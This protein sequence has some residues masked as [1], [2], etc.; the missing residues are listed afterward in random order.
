[1]LSISNTSYQL[2]PDKVKVG[3]SSSPRPT[4][5]QRNVLSSG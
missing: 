3:G 2:T 5:F 4:N 1:M